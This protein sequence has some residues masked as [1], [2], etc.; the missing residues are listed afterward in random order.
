MEDVT[1]LQT[2]ILIRAQETCDQ[3]THTHHSSTHQHNWDHYLWMT[4]FAC[5]HVVCASTGET[6]L[7]LSSSFYPSNI[8]LA[9]LSSIQV[10][11][12]RCKEFSQAP[13]FEYIQK[14]PCLSRGSLLRVPRTPYPPP[15]CLLTS[16]RRWDGSPPPCS[17]PC[18]MLCH[19][20]LMPMSCSCYAHALL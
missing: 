18:A 9:A 7:F 12:L 4:K 1:N 14:K 13:D 3:H 8:L 15:C 19:A 5:T 11:L 16:V 17:Y 10:F 20:M 6:P 2:H